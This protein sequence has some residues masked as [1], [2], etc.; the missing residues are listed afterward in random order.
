MTEDANILQFPKSKI[1]RERMPDIE[2]INKLKEK[3]MQNFA[4]TLVN[5][6]SD[7][8]LHDLSSYGIDIED[9]VFIKDFYFTTMI[10]SAAIYRSLKV[11]HP[12]HSYIDTHVQV[13]EKSE[14]EMLDKT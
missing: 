14:E 8:I 11:E 5:D 1:Y 6:I 9:D 4:D 3:G 2:E 7:N 13:I 12:M 10:L